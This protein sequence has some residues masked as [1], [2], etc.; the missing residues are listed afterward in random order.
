ML[1]YSH[2]FFDRDLSWLSFNYRVLLEGKND[3]VP[4][5]E[6]ISFLSIFS[7]N[8]D[9][10]FRVR[11]ASVRALGDLKKETIQKHLFFNPKQALENI[12][13]VVYHY[14]DEFGH[15]VR[16]S[17]LPQLK[18]QGIHLYYRDDILPAHQEP[19]AYYFRTRVLTFLQPVIMKGRETKSFFL[20]N[21]ALYFAIRLLE[22]TNGESRVVYAHINIPSGHLPRFIELPS[23]QGEHYYIFLDDC[24][25]TN[26]SYI[27]PGYKVL[28]CFS[29]KL[30][31]DADL[32]IDDEYSGNLVRKIKKQLPKRT[33]GAPTRFLYESGMPGEFRDFVRENFGLQE[34]DM[35]AGGRYHNLN[36]LK[37]LPNPLSPQLKY[38][39]LPPLPHPTLDG[40]TS[41]FEAI[42]AGDHMLHL[43]YH[44]YDN[45]L[46][47]FNEA[48]IDPNVTEIKVTLY[49][50]ASHSFIA[51]ALISAAR[52]GKKVVVFVEVKARFDEDNNLRWAARMKTAG[53]HIIY[54]IPGLKVH[55]KVALIKR[56]TPEGKITRYGFFGTGNFNE[57]TARIYTDHALLT[58][59]KGLTKE[60][61]NVFSYLYKKK[62]PLPFNELLVSQFNL[63]DRFL[64][65]LDREIEH[66]RNGR[67][68]HIIIKLNNLEEETMIRKLYEASQAG[69]KIDLIIRSIC[70]LVPDLPGMS[71]NIRVIRLV[72]R[73][74]E[75]ARVFIFSNNN[76]EETFLA[77]AD[78]MNRNLHRRIEVG[79]PIY[80]PKLKAEI[81][82]IIDFQ[83]NDTCKAVQLDT[84]QRN[85][86]IKPTEGSEPLRAQTAIY[87]YVQAKAESEVAEEANT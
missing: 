42:D 68:A 30:N 26:L 54:S 47:L 70:G 38:T 39:P 6:R 2:P 21:G 44:S 33:Q 77:S 49:R 31:R 36:D 7:S 1:D 87:E 85:L 4:L 48:A 40:Y 57:L 81:R 55:A 59:H 17:I 12:L 86:F 76:N 41:I 82:Q 53:V 25:R 11:V 15:T 74:L 79:F 67:A 8:L 64:Y 78:W 73:F 58:S 45:I 60:L 69:V 52:N 22:E 83:L 16:H 20:E 9:E 14:Q 43:P 5:Y 72:D 51:N 3:E 56:R 29:I 24:I 50:I 10:F 32:A 75:H 46:R 37:E 80:D 35:I 18:A 34:H 84:Q 61:N 28:D 19:V 13:E 62:Q 27:F 23:L 65:L 66:A 71:D 63:V